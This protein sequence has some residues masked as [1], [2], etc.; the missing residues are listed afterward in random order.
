MV[1]PFSS[2]TAQ[3]AMVDYES[4]TY[5]QERAYLE[6]LTPTCW[7][8]KQGFVP[9][10]KVMALSFLSLSLPFFSRPTHFAFFAHTY[11]HTTQPIR[12]AIQTTRRNDSVNFLYP[13]LT[14]LPPYSLSA[15]PPHPSLSQ[16]EG[17]F[18]VN[19][20]LEELMMEELEQ[21][22]SARGVGGFLPAVKQ[23]ANVAALPG[24]VGVRFC[25]LR[26][27]QACVPQP[28]ATRPF[29][30]QAGAINFLP[31]SQYSV[32]L[33]DV[34]SGYGFAIGNMAAFDVDDPEAVVSPGKSQLTEH[35]FSTEGLPSM[36]KYVDTFIH[37]PNSHSLSRSP[38]PQVASV[39]T[40]TAVYASFAQTSTWIRWS[41]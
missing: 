23:I 26:A 8:I 25:T 21:Y 14:S 32:G 1:H 24:I 11:T 34:H 35:Y 18:Y 13:L 17:R 10:M 30:T 29:L 37:N 22:A 12:Y 15:T 6:R 39:L 19:R 36:R 31:T 27:A 4:R 5:E 16:V 40:S 2:T 28:S 20:H 33:P 41:R 38:P 9:N 7:K 3:N